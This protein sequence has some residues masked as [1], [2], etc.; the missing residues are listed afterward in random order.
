MLPIGE[1]TMETSVKGGKSR[2]NHPLNPKMNFSDSG[3]GN[4]CS[5]V[6]YSFSLTVFEFIVINYNIITKMKQKELE[7][8]AVKLINSVQNVFFESPDE[9]MT[10]EEFVVVF[11]SAF[12]AIVANMDDEFESDGALTIMCVDRLM[13]VLNGVNGFRCTPCV[14]TCDKATLKCD[15]SRNE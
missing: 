2:A 7:N 12:A 1:P 3:K 11:A 10:K 9:K 15:V 4:L 8:F 5:R 6:T 13:N 14:M